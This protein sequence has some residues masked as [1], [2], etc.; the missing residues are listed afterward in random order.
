MKLKQ[1]LSTLIQSNIIKHNTKKI[2]QMCAT[3]WLF[4][5]VRLKAGSR[6]SGLGTVL[7]FIMWSLRLVLFLGVL[8]HYL[9]FSVVCLFPTI[10]TTTLYT[11]TSSAVCLNTLCIDSL[12]VVKLEEMFVLTVKASFIST[13]ARRHPWQKKNWYVFFC[14]LRLSVFLFSFFFSFGSSLTKSYLDLQRIN[15]Q[16]K[17]NAWPLLTVFESFILAD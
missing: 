6:G 1:M 11:A 16:V 9:S 4:C 7:V 13:A 3:C 15:S 12:W 14:F 17:F 2:P 8:A 10:H 5:Y